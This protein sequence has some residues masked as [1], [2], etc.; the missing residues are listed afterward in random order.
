M[1]PKVEPFISGD[2]DPKTFGLERAK[3]KKLVKDATPAGRSSTYAEKLWHLGRSCIAGGTADRLLSS[4]SHECDHDR[5]KSE[6]TEEKA[7]E[8]Y[9]KW[10]QRLQQMSGVHK[11]S[12]DQ[13]ALDRMSEITGANAWKNRDNVNYEKPSAAD[14]YKYTSDFSLA[15]AKVA[16]RGLTDAKWETSGK[17]SPYVRERCLPQP[18]FEKFPGPL[19]IRMGDFPAR[20]R[21]RS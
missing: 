1:A 16:E 12:K 8:I 4:I 21:E 10:K 11:K 2:A 7:Q 20:R 18:L 3:F 14:V 5:K 6:P 19:K 9:K 13:K 17:E 15:F